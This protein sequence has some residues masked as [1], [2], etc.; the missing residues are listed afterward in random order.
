MFKAIG[1]IFTLGAIGAGVGEYYELNLPTLSWGFALSRNVPRLGW[2]PEGGGEVF[3]WFGWLNTILAFLFGLLILLRFSRA[4]A[5]TPITVRKIERF[6]SIKRGY[7]SFLF[8]L[9]L[10][11]VAALDHVLVGSDALAVRHDGEWSFPAFSREIEKGEKYGLE[12]DAALSAPNYR[13]LKAEFKE[14]GKGERVIMP[15][16]PYAPTGDNIPAVAIPL[17]LPDGAVAVSDGEPYK[18][19]ACRVFDLRTPEDVHLRYRFR[20]GLKH[21]RVDGWD[22]EKNRVY[23]ARY[24]EGILV[25]GSQTW[26]GAGE[27][28]DFLK[29]TDENYYM[30]RY[31][32]SPPT[33]N[34]SPRHPM[35]TTS[36]GYD[37]ISYLYG[38]LKVNIQSTL[39]YIPIV[40]L[41][42][43]SLGLLMGYFGGTFDLVV[44]RII[45]ILSNIPFL[46]LIIIV[47]EAVPPTWKD[48]FGLYVILGILVVFGWMRMTYL[49]RTAAL[50]EK[51]RDYI[52]ASR[53]LGASTPRIIFRH[54]LPNSV[55]IVVTLVPFSVSGLILALTSLDYLGF[56][57]PPKYATWGKLLRDGLENLSSP[58]L[59]TSAFLSLVVLLIL[60]TFVGEA[61]REAF[62]PKKYTYYR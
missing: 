55:A 53:V 35:G 59:V 46:F 52:A 10:A 6:K 40:Y 37:V 61:V 30:V 9:A 2:I 62:D 7:Y 44:Q 42:G 21:G 5:L 32:P 56:G 45:E 54:L 4:G 27:V 24:A 11:G 12:G 18:G 58:W 25:P 39:L 1:C 31:P 17:E 3:P 33:M 20:K 15:L 41:I 23:E 19:L 60:V 34:S 49:M 26:N 29:L 38:G 57:L 50:K 13:E 47:S 36:Q 8:L 28:E 51:A 48:R 22:R 14:A 16:W 43:V